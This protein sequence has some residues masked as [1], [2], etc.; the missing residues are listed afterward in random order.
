MW[1]RSTLGDAAEEA[2][3]NDFKPS[4]EERGIKRRLP[5]IPVL[6][7]AAVVVILLFVSLHG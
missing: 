7:I 1:H 3:D 2:T 5:W 4:W 6:G